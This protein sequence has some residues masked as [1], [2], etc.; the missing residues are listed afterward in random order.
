MEQNNIWTVIP[1]YNE[2]AHLEKVLKDLKKYTQNL[3]V[4]DDGSTDLTVKIAKRYTPHVLV[5]TVNLGKGAALKTAC[6]YAFGRPGAQAV[7]MLDAD[8]QHDPSLIPS[9]I[10][11]LTLG[12]KLLFGIRELKKMPPDRRF[13][14]QL[15]TALIKY[16]Y[17][18]TIYDIL[19]GY[20]AISKSI[21][22]VLRWQSQGYAV[23]LE[24]AAKTAKYK[25]PFT[26]IKIPTK[27]HPY[28]RGM[29]AI[30][31]IKTTSKLI[32]LQV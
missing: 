14:N 29:N 8:G 27:Y 1:A 23:E 26:Y 21:Y 20:K 15:T 22:Q 7:I 32:T 30:D 17:G 18:V 31:A 6:D 12:K 2:S 13:A 24:I 9:F 19:S 4:A 28:R 5:H 10:N 16:K 3:V 25:L 11:Q